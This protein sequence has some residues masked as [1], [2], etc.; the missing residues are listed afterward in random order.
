MLLSSQVNIACLN[1]LDAIHGDY[2]HTITAMFKGD[3]LI[4][5]RILHP[6]EAKVEELKG[7]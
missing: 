6:A 3:F 1:T 5:K 4:A 2:R 7:N